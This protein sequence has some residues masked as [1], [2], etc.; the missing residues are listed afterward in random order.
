MLERGKKKGQIA[1]F[2]IIAIVLVGGVLAYFVVK[3]SLGTRAVPAEFQ[4]VFDAY[5]QCIQVEGRNAI[6]VLESQGGNLNSE[7]APG[8][9]YAPFSSQLNF[10]GFPVAYWYYVS[11]NGLVKQNVPTKTQMQNQLADYARERL[12]GCDLEMFYKKGLTINIGTPKVTAKINAKSVEFNVNA[13]ISVSRE[14][15][16]A[17]KLSHSA[18]IESK[19]GELYDAALSIYNKQLK[20]AFFENYSVDV[21]RLY[22]PVDG[23]EV[24]C[25]PK[26][27]KTRDVMNELKN[28]LSANLGSI[29][30]KGDYYTLQNDKNK[31]FVVNLPVGK[32][33]SVMYNTNWPTKIEIYGDGVEDEIMTS[34][35]V[36]NQQGLGVMGFCYLP[37][38]FVYDVSFPVMVQISDGMEIFQFPVVVVVDKN[39]PRQGIYSEIDE[40]EQIDVCEFKT[41]DISINVYDSNLNVADAELSY[42]CFNQ[43]CS[44]GKSSNGI[45]NAKAPACVNGYIEA[46]AEGYAPAKQLFSSNEQSSADVILNKEY[47]VDFEVRVDGSRVNERVLVIFNS[48][49]GNSKSLVLPEVSSLNLSE[50]QYDISAYVYANSSLKIPESTKRQCTEVPRSGLLGFFGATQEQ[51]VDITIPETIIESALVAGGMQKD[52]LLA[53]DL[54]RGKAAISVSSLGKP[55]SI[56]ELQNNFEAFNEQGVDIS[57]P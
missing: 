41:Q 25:S 42:G 4:E 50:G 47:N 48:E 29:K 19:L 22:T 24:S 28:A 46:R 57:F 5:Q 13:D 43:R 11:G 7:Y 8:S 32:D 6:S 1:I 18:A 23:V 54:E 21:L 9:E 55:N 17:R 20:E 26:I 56:E 38:H 14:S 33:V 36:G 34:K 49:N 31:Y 10:L 3:G 2:I 30:F 52:Y 37:Y 45:L 53:S 39:K 40:N 12:A 51:C 35:P 15:S 44:L 16:N 27:W